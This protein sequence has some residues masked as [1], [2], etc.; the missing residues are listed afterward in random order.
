[1]RREEKRERLLAA[2]RIAC[3]TGASDRV[4]MAILNELA[5]LLA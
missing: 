1:V 3:A 5:E 2:Y 4:R